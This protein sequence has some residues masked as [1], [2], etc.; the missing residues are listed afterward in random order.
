MQTKGF[1]R[2]LASV[3]SLAMVVMMPMSSV[4]AAEDTEPVVSFALD[5]TY[6]QAG[7]TV[8]L[9]VNLNN[10]PEEGWNL[11]EF[12]VDYDSDQLEPVVAQQ[13]SGSKLE[14]AAGSAMDIVNSK[15]D[16]NTA[17]KPILGA[18]I[19]SEN[20]KTEGEYLYLS[21]KVKDGVET[22]DTITITG[23]V[24]RFARSVIVDN[25]VQELVEL[26]QPGTVQEL[27][28]EVK[29]LILESIAVTTPPVKQVYLE[30][31]DALDVTGGK[32]TLTYNYGDTQEVDLAMDMVTGFD[33]TVAGEQTLTVTYEG[34]TTTFTVTIQAKALTSIEISK[35]ADRLSYIKDQPL[36]L[37]GLEVTAHYDNDTTEKV[38]ITEDMVTGFDSA[39]LGEQTVTITY[40]EKEAEFTVKVIRYGDVNG[41]GEITATDALLALQAATNKVTLTGISLE[42]ADVDGTEGI[43]A[44]DALQILQFVTKKI[45]S[46]S[47]EQILA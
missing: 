28:T 39:V 1:R 31:K 3:S 46:F 23:T 20:Q 15:T 18:S 19:S 33:N 36:D 35:P 42:A 6:V 16:V 7:D 14:W 29:P 4:V 44:T 17:V 5:K 30:G 8:K 2:I 47:V 10:L 21:F 24:N 40:G 27:N 38:E 41:D 37:T 45:S 43:I 25:A 32:L 12:A 11:L 34:K 26:M 9:S 22:G 13:D